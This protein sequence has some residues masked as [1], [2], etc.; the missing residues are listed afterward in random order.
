M[1]GDFFIVGRYI[2]YRDTSFSCC[3]NVR[4]YWLVFLY[5]VNGFTIS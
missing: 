2:D 4:N 3:F 1:A 5:P